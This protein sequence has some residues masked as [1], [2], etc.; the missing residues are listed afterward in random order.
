MPDT[1]ALTDRELLIEYM[2]L[3]ISEEDWHGVA[4]A[5]MDLREMD[6]FQ[7]GLNHE[8][9]CHVDLATLYRSGA[10]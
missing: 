7:R 6:A 2:Q 8:V 1:H 5:A 4:D 3:K 9:Q 10:L